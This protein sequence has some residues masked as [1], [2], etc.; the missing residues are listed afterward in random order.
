MKKLARYGFLLLLLAA[1]ISSCTQDMSEVRLD[2]QVGTSDQMNITSDSASVVGFIVAQGDG[3]SERG[4]CYNTEANPTT[5]NN[6]K[7]YEGDDKSATFTVR[8]GGLTYAT[9]YYAR[10]YAINEN[11]TIYGEEISFT[12]LPI[13]PTVTT[14][15]AS[16]ITS[17][18]A[19]TG[20]NVTADGGA[21]VT[22]RG[23]CW[24]TSAT[25]TTADSK[26]SDGD[27]TGEF[28]SSITGLLGNTQYYV[29]AYATNSAGTA[30]GPAVTLSTLVG[31]PEVTT[32]PVT[33]ITKTSAVTGGTISY[34]GGGI[35][36]ERGLVWSTSANP[37]TASNKIT[38]SESEVDWVTNLS[39]LTLNTTYHVRAY[40]T[41]SAGTAYG[42]DV[43][44]TTLADITKF[45]VV[46]DYNGWGNNDNASYIISTATSNG[47]AEGYVYLTSGGIKLTTDHSWDDAHT[48]GDDGSGNL[49]NP[50]NNINV[51]ADGYYR[52][53]ANLNDMTYSLLKTDWGVIG[54]ATPNGWN[55][56]TA[57][58]YNSTSKTWRGVMALTAAS[59]KFRANH[60]WDYNYGS[61]AADGTLGAGEANIAI[62]EAGDYSIELDL[63]V[64]NEYKY[65]VYRWGLIGSATAGGWDT[66]QNMSW[67]TTLQVFTVTLD[68]AVGEIKFRAND[69]WDVNYGGDLNALTPGG[70]NIAISEAGNYTVTF[71][72]WTLKATV[73]K[74]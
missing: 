23:V 51:A 46:G 53:R 26:T 73:T 44:F 65:R 35:I 30:Y 69:G 20:G 55:D 42:D 24:S 3:F 72:P 57:L 34:N 41:N 2:P 62:S 50:G 7:I 19:T 4:I 13:I 14:T 47:Q 21:D 48:F 56:E 45:W 27:G 68:L 29:R 12:T 43:A 6:K 18:S 31:L 11:G 16:A 54:D 22:A 63:S 71:N 25:P 28:A 36:T 37:T 9:K 33:E 66:D 15:E 8:L 60:N 5:A 70:A 38:A 74:N 40:A 32:K 67:N 10:A 59:I 52:I 39:S 61:D 64:P 49:T 58:T 1:M 17:N